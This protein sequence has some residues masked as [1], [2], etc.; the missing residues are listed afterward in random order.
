MEI[1]SSPKSQI[2]KM[3]SRS[4]ISVILDRPS[5]VGEAL[6]S[7]Q[8]SLTVAAAMTNDHNQ[9]SFY[10]RE[11]RP[12]I[13]GVM[14]MIL[15][16]ANRAMNVQRSATTQQITQMAE[17]IVETWW[18]LRIDEVAYAIRQGVAGKY[19]AAY[20]KF[21]AE[22][23]A[24]WLEKYDTIE[25]LDHIHIINSAQRKQIQD[26]EKE[27]GNVLDGYR[28]LQETYQ[29]T[30]KDAL[31]LQKEQREQEKRKAR[32]QEDDFLKWQAQYFA[33]KQIEREDESH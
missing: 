29:S 23:L 31:T 6:A 17:E 28:R 16:E 24:T 26:E 5:N 18:M 11:N 27:T 12:M 9:I 19:G 8:R 2:T 21:D 4:L 3:S 1:Q 30:G 10:R 22:T 33:N 15:V 20:G 14:S 32:W 25:R 7:Y 13:V